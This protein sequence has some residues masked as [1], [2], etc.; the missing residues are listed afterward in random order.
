MELVD[1]LVVDDNEDTCEVLRVAF[2]IQGLSVFTATDSGAALLSLSERKPT[3]LLLDYRF[4]DLDLPMFVK[5]IRTALPQT[6]IILASAILDL[7]KQAD[8]L[9]IKYILSKP[10]DMDDLVSA[11]RALCRAS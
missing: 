6:K 10:F 8:L 9:G 2:A 11:V 7:R 1:I 3:V 4:P 5:S